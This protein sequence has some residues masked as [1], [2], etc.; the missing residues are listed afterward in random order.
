MKPILQ[1]IVL[2]ERIYEDKSNKKIIA[3]TFNQI[4]IGQVPLVQIQAPDGT[5]K[6]G[7][8]GGTDPGCPVLYI[9][10]TDVVDGTELTLQFVN[11]S[12]NITIFQTGLR[13]NSTN[14]LATVEIVAPLPPMAVLGREHGD[15]SLDILWNGEI[16]GSHRLLV[17]HSGQT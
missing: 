2:A 6:T 8:P 4:N 17:R 9:S 11:M 3:G 12:K 5:I 13:I 15:F 16:I 10:L 7:L 14:R 1:A